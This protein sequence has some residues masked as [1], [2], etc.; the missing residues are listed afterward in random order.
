[1]MEPYRA[2]SSVCMSSTKHTKCGL[3]IDTNVP[4]NVRKSAVKS[5]ACLL[6]ILLL[7]VKHGLQHV[8]R[9]AFHL[10]YIMV[11]VGKMQIER[12][13]T[14]TTS[15]VLLRSLLVSPFSYRYL[16]MH[17]DALPH[18]MASDPSAS[19]MRIEKSASTP[20]SGLPINTSPSL[21]YACMVSCSML[22]A[23]FDGSGMA[24]FC[25]STYI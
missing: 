15:A 1:M 18:I 8:Y 23:A 6:V 16:P 19:K 17:R 3:P 4:R 22:C 7:V 10:I 13:H 14:L 21:P 20:S 25:V 9:D 24:Y 2:M 12:L 5:I 11:F